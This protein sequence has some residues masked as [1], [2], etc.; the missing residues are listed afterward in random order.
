MKNKYEINLKENLIHIKYYIKIQDISNNC[1][2]IELSDIKLKICG[3][4]L[5]INRLDQYEMCIIGKC[6]N[7]ELIYE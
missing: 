2:L 3:D 1:I 4:N 6:R 7:I 5:I